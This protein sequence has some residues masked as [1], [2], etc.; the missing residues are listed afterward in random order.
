VRTSP[1]GS[2]GYYGTRDLLVHVG[3]D[4]GIANIATG[5]D[6]RRT[7]Q[8]QPKDALEVI[9]RNGPNSFQIMPFSDMLPLGYTTND[10]PISVSG[11]FGAENVIAQEF[12]FS[13]DKVALLKMY[14]DLQKIAY[15][16]S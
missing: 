8:F 4:L 16:F 13:V 14:C 3:D 2:V 7:G 15:P 12:Q 11:S 9:R 5:L 10:Q 6:F 1:N